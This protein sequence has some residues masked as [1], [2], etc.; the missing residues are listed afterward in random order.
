VNGLIKNAAKG[1]GLYF[2]FLHIKA[3]IGSRFFFIIAAVAMIAYAA[4]VYVITSDLR[5]E[6]INATQAYAALIESVV[7][8]N[9][10]YG[11][12]TKTLKSMIGGTNT[13]VIVTDTSG[14]PIMWENIYTGLL[15]KKKE[16][17]KL[18]PENKDLLEQKLN[19]FKANYAPRPLY[20]GKNSEKVGYLFLGNTFLMQSL[21]LL[22][23]FE[24]CL[25]IAV[26]VFIYFA[27]R[28]IRITERS[29]LWVGLAKETAH[30]LGT[31]ISSLM[32][33][34]EYM[35]TYQDADPPIEAHILVNQVQRICNDMDNDLKR[36]SK[37]A[38]RF[39]QIGSIPAL[40]PCDINEVLMDV[41]HYFRVRLPLLRKKIEVKFNFGE[42]PPVDVNRDLLEWVFENLMKNSIDAMIRVD[43]VI[44]IKTEYV[45]HDNLLRIYHIDNGKGIGKDA[46][47]KIFAPGYT[48]KKRGWGLGL[49]LAKRIVE[50]YHKGKICVSWSQKDKGTIFLIELPVAKEADTGDSFNREE[51]HVGRPQESTVG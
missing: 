26:V 7:S 16:L 25:G 10:S 36:L 5:T 34:V 15:Y 1:S 43:G 51:Q 18:T 20:A 12:A 13:P 24:V 42:I 6:T 17:D 3:F 47:K 39:G 38:N 49:T 22:P 44:E 45:R 32:G 2:L 40:N 50:D 11:D 46:Q 33:W 37:V 41:A 30:Q 9:M 27:F 29:N 23:F 8:N 19:E 31:P 48:T 14:E 35:R 28:T 4:F 21:Y